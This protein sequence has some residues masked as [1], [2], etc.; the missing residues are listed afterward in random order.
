LSKE[1][2]VNPWLEEK[3]KK[4]KSP[5]TIPVVVEVEP[6]KLEY[7]LS[8]L[9]KITGVRISYARISFGRYIPDIRSVLSVFS[10]KKVDPLIGEMRISSV[11]IPG[12]PTWAIA[13]LPLTPLMQFFK[14]KKLDVE[15]VP[16]GDIRTVIGAPR[17]AKI[18]TKVAVLDTGANPLSPQLR[19]SEMLSKHVSEHVKE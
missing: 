12:V 1:A 7:V 6:A 4:M 8:E 16:T 17:I 3:L 13:S 19:L 5:E 14:L 10:L 18:K 2:K 15:I 11:E 9:R